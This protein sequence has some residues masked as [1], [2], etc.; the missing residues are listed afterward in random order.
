MKKI[1][2]LKVKIFCDG[3]DKKDMLDMNSKNFIKG[4]TTNPSLISLAGV[5][6]Y[7]NY[8]IKI[9]KICKNK[10]ISLE[11]FSDDVDSMIRQAYLIN[12]WGKNVYVKIPVVNT[13]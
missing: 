4:F 12:S 11:V 6:N 3:V 1:E 8:S 2:A 13:Q 7:K 9:L 5:K 10:P